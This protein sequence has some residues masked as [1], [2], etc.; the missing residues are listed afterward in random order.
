[1]SHGQVA[2][3][4]HKQPGGMTPRASANK[5]LEK[6]PCLYRPQVTLA[7]RGRPI[8]SAP[9][10]RTERGCVDFIEVDIGLSRGWGPA[11]GLSAFFRGV[12]LGK[13][14][15]KVTRQSLE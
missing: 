9:P 4:G 13:L 15:I 11:T 14:R 10:R 12:W 6:Y 7:E 8:C 1:M 3:P 5:R 2:I